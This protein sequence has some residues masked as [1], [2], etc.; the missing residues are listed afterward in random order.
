[1]IAAKVLR[2]AID[3]EPVCFG[4]RARQNFVILGGGLAGLAAAQELLKRG[5]KVTLI[6]QGAEVGGLA[7]TFEQGGFRFDIGGH[8]FHSNN[9]TVVQWLKDL[10]GKDLRVVPRTSHIY[11]NQQFVN[12]PIQL[13]G[14]LSIFSPFKAAQ[15]VFSYLVAKF[16]EKTRQ[17]ISFED[18]VIKRY[19]RALYEVFFQPYT[20]KVWGIACDQ[21]SATWA[22]QRIGI[23]SLWRMVK[24]AIA[25][26]KETPATAI[27]EF[28]YPRA[29]FGMIP[30][31]LRENILAMGGT[32]HTHT[33]LLSC[34]P[35]TQGFEVN[36]RHQD[37]TTLT[38]K[39]DQIVSTIPLNSLLQAIPE[40]LGSQ[41]I[42]QSYNLEYRDIICL[43]VA[44]KRPQ[45]SQDS[46]TY[47]PMKDLIF[48]RTHEP[49]N[50]SPEMVPSNNYTSLAIEI[51]SSRGEPTWEMSDDAILN[52]VIEQMHQIGWISKADVHKSWVLR[53][54]YAYPVYRVGYEPTLSKVKDYLNQWD[55]LHL[56]GRTGSFHYM[57]SDG[58]I[59][60]VFRLIEKLFP[61]GAAQVQPLS[62]AAG[63]W[64]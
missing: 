48:G 1:M 31:A 54:P 26:A 24:Q 59:E 45:V 9:P 33:A 20:E 21:L 40:K 25:P 22:S 43:F 5:C 38:L 28:Y 50:W 8:R 36:V 55:N 7:R 61:E 32:I 39:A 17:D 30:D 16:T 51:F 44:L 15:M 63:R 52:K 57:N 27:S 41:E 18:W 42:L 11:L 23:P 12:Y 4:T 56:V 47:F 6:E 35:L 37:G 13:P 2:D 60:D 64:M 46:W 62:T 14:A 49:K 58:V 34:T 29:G 3:S 19:G 10:L 53:V